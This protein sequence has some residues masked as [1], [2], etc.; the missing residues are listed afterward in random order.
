MTPDLELVPERVRSA[1]FYVWRR[2]QDPSRCAVLLDR[3]EELMCSDAA[4]RF[5]N[6]T[7]V[8]QLYRY[9]GDMVELMCHSGLLALAAS[10]L[11]ACPVLSDFSLNQV[12][13]GELPDPWHID[14][15]FNEMHSLASGSLLGLQCIMPLSPFTAENGATQL[16][17][18]SHLSYS[19]PPADVPAEVATFTAAPGDLLVMAASTWHRA[20][21]NSTALPRTA[22]LFCFVEKWIRPMTGPPE[23]GPWSATSSTRLLLG[24]D[25]PP[26]NPD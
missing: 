5:P 4:R 26:R 7:R 25:R 16:V 17:P 18:G 6:S 13:R 15:P 10:L 9:G 20:G 12:S 23:P 2:F 11:G 1:G 8:W 24:L 21:I 3:A 19:H 14:Y 22:V